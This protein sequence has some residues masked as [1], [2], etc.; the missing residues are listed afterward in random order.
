M[1]ASGYS[2]RAKYGRS[3]TLGLVIGGFLKS[4][5]IGSIATERGDSGPKA[6]AAALLGGAGRR[7]GLFSDVSGD[8]VLPTSFQAA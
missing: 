2:A 4:D 6:R 3:E 5:Q 8:S 7:L 1:T